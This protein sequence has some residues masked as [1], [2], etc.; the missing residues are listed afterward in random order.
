[1]Y[2]WKSNP[3]LDTPDLQTCQVEGPL[4]SAETRAKFNPPAASWTMYGGVVRPKSRG[5]IRLTGPKPPYPDRGQYAVRPGRPEGRGS[6]RGALSRDWQFGRASTLHKARS[7]ARQPDRNCIGRLHSR[8]GLHLPPSDVYREN[9]AR[10]DVGRR[11]STQGLWD[12]KP[13]HCRRLDHAARDHRQYHGSLHHHRR[14]CR[15]GLAERA[16]A[17][18]IVGIAQRR[19]RALDLSTSI[20]GISISRGSHSHE[21]HDQY[22]FWPRPPKRRYSARTSPLASA[23]RPGQIDPLLVGPGL[24]GM[25]RERTSAATRIGALTVAQI[26][27]AALETR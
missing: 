19:R 23:W 26:R 6:V 7:H 12:R 16:Q 24:E 3:G 13:S 21:R 18:D 15:G 17:R 2:F 5:R 20:P 8:R 9:G 22:Q 25:R 4:C 14:A 10:F 1:M 11:R 27:S